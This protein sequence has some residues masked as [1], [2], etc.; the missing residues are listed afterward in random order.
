MNTS[1]RAPNMLD[2]AAL[3]GVSHQ[4]V[5]RVVN[6]TGVVAPATRRRVLAA[7]ETLGYRR[8]LA[9]SRLA[10]SRSTVIGVLGPATANYGPTSSLY[11]VE[12]AIRDAGYH[13]LITSTEP[14]QSR[15]SLEF[16][17]SQSVS[18]LVV[19]AP[20]RPVLDALAQAG[21][22]L[23]VV[24][25]QAGSAPPGASVAV[26][27]AAGVRLLM[28][29]LTGL[30]HRRIQHLAGPGDF[31]DAELR[32]GAFGRALA[33]AGLPVLP[34]L[35]GDW[36]AESGYRAGPQLDPQAT[37]VLCGNDQ[38][39]FGLIHA[40]ARSGRRVP[41]D[42]SVAGFDDVPE[43]AHSLPPLTTVH[44]D[45]ARTGREAVAVLLARLSGA[46]APRATRLQ[47]AL[48]P[49]ASTGRPR[50]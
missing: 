10:T 50:G 44:Q 46:D 41:E 15:D 23:P 47:P 34:V 48:V 27:Q 29:H 14:A 32:R 18:A 19:I 7:I 37:A 16:L 38:M 26:D 8:N 17:L 5:W 49:R 45:F 12:H 42:V 2:V 20:Y 3:A 6:E 24:V 43:A 11:A 13:P 9:A 22:D 4:T 30:G 39:A 25:L 33:R 21:P 35:A 40:L 31:I 1:R 28:A 36:S